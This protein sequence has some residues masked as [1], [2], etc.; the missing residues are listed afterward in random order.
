MSVM[1]EMKDIATDIKNKKE[2]IADL[3]AQLDDVTGLKEQIKELQEQVK[4]IIAADT[5][6]FA[7]SE[8]IKARTKELNQ[9]GKLA[10]K[11]RSFKPAIAVAFA[12]ALAKSDEAVDAVKLKGKAFDFL[13]NQK[14]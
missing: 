4:A 5:E 9:A 7:L 8:Y 3:V 6:I 13:D 10:A 12:K 1:N 2:L 14:G 11:D